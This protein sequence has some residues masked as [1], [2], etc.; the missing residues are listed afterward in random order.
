MFYINF[1]PI[2]TLRKKTNQKS[3]QQHKHKLGYCHKIPY[4]HSYKT[5]EGKPKAGQRLQAQWSARQ[6]HLN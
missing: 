6:K 1:Y 2:P 5:L 4:L 3:P